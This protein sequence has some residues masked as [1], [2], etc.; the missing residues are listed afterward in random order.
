MKNSQ[1]EDLNFANT[2]ENEIPC[3][4]HINGCLESFYSQESLTHHKHKCSFQPKKCELCLDHYRLSDLAC[5]YDKCSKEEITCG[6][7]GFLARR[8]DYNHSCH[9]IKFFTYYFKQYVEESLKTFG[10]TK[11]VDYEEN[12]LKFKQEI[13]RNFSVNKDLIQKLEEDISDVKSNYNSFNLKTDFKEDFNNSE[14][15]QSIMNLIEQNKESFILFNSEIERLNEQNKVRI[16]EHM[17]HKSEINQISDH[18]EAKFEKFRNKIE[19][20]VRSQIYSLTAELSNINLKVEKNESLNLELTKNREFISSLENQ[21]GN[22][23][24]ETNLC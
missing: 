21:I 7:C 22:F 19:T 16:K 23:R 12:L 5:H 6:E 15:K 2:N 13:N 10:N 24:K 8:K 20:Q 3:L 11:S 4:F 17:S 9:L 18:T 1:N 14:L